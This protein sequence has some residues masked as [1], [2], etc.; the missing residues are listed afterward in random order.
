MSHHRGLKSWCLA[1]TVLA[2]LNLAGCGPFLQCLLG[3]VECECDPEPQVK[4]EGYWMLTE[5]LQSHSEDEIERQ[6]RVQ[7]EFWQLTEMAT[8]AGLGVYEIAMACQPD[9]V[10]GYATLHDEGT[11]IINSVHG[12]VQAESVLSGDDTIVGVTTLGGGIWSIRRI[13]QPACEECT[14]TGRMLV[15]H[16]PIEL[17]DEEPEVD[18]DPAA[19]AGQAAP[20]GL[21]HLKAAKGSRLTLGDEYQRTNSA[22][23]SNCST[24]GAAMDCPGSGGGHPGYVECRTQS[25]SEGKIQALADAVCLIDNDQVFPG[26]LLQG[27]H[28]DGGSFVPVTIPRSGGRLVLSGLALDRANYSINLDETA[29]DTVANAIARLLSDNQVLG[30]AAN[31]SYRVDTVYSS[32]QW[33]FNLGTNVQFMSTD[34]AASANTS[35]GS[36]DNT[37]IMQFTQ[38]FYTISFRDPVTATSVFKDG[39]AFNDPEGQIGTGNPPLYVSNVKYG[40]QVYFIAKSSLGSTLVEAALKGAYSGAASVTV[41]S[42]MSYQDIMAKTSITYIVRGG[43][44]DLA[45]AP[46]AAATPD[47]MYDKVREFLSNKNAAQFSAAN[48]GVPVAYTLRYLDDRTVAMKGLSTTYDR[49]DCSTVPSQDYQ[50]TVKAENIDDDLWIWLDNDNNAGLK[51]YT[52]QRTMP[53]QNINNWLT[54]DFDHV[55]IVK[56]GNGGCFGTSAKVTFYLDGA[57]IWSDNYAPYGWKDCGW[58]TDLRVRVNRKTRKFELVNVWHAH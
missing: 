8:G 35:R 19:P 24:N 17:W 42:G 47:Q 14:Q 52:N 22:G 29:Q 15:A 5:V 39:D 43:G 3:N 37:V 11:V 26:A 28:F 34:I 57:Q 2:S 12:H 32:N 27:A 36:T 55:V 10:I 23:T 56:L 7:V 51:A 18:P 49:H 45:L 41:E 25:M 53:S 33:A 13:E 6:A 46:I 9:T 4:L 38:V 1:T 40:R 20:N 21:E 31:A 44:A 30:T 54:D 50:F 48:P 58:Q 16:A